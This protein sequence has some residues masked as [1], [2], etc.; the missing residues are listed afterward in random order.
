MA[1]DDFI[2]VTTT[3]ATG[4]QADM[5]ARELVQRRLAA[6]VQVIGPIASTYPWQGNIETSEEWQCVAKTRRE[7]FA[8]VE[9][10]IRE[11]H[12]YEV[13]EIIATPIVAGSA[14]YLEWIENETRD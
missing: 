5:L 8:E 12:T 11:L 6:C 1:S 7:R 4:E 10:I 14:A 13:P 2:Q 3:A 9:Q